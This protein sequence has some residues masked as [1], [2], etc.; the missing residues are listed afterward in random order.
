[1]LKDIKY[2]SNLISVQKAFVSIKKKRNE[3]F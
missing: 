2:T 1:M 3:A